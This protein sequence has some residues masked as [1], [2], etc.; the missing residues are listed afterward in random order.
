MYER[1]GSPLLLPSGGTGPFVVTY[2]P[3]SFSPPVVTIEIAC[4]R[5]THFML[6]AEQ[7]RFLSP[8]LASSVVE[9]LSPPYAIPP[10]HAPLGTAAA[11]SRQITTRPPPARG[12]PAQEQAAAAGSA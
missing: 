4:I 12:S 3:R 7:S 5:D 6:I 8:Q 10:P 1:D 2:F 11:A 9:Q